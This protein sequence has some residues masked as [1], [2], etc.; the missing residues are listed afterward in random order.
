MFAEI[1]SKIKI[2]FDTKVSK[3]Q[4]YTNQSLMTYFIFKAEKSNIER[5][6]LKVLPAL[7]E[8]LQLYQ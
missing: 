6:N 4:Y 1:Y 7:V 8:K 3:A 5:T 2:H